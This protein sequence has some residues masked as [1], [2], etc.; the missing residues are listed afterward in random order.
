MSI[1]DE[2]ARANPIPRTPA[3]RD[4]PALAA[5]MGGTSTSAPGGA[6][7]GAN[8]PPRVSQR[9][10][11]PGWM[12]GVIGLALV[13]ACAG[14]VAWAIGAARPDGAGRL[15]LGAPSQAPTTPSRPSTGIT[16]PDTTLD[17]LAIQA[18]PEVRHSITVDL[19]VDYQCRYC[20]RAETTFGP[21]LEQLAK[22][23]D[24]K[25]N[26]H[27]RSFLD[28]NLGNTSSTMAAIAATCADTV[29]AFQ[30]YHD[31]A[32]AHQPIREGTGYTDE[33]LRSTFAQDAG[34]TA[35]KLTSFQQCFDDRATAAFVKAMESGNMSTA[36]PGND[37]FRNGVPAVPTFLVDNKTID[38]TAMPSDAA[39]MLTYL[40]N[41]AGEPDLAVP[42]SAHPPTNTASPSSTG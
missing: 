28:A 7:G 31:V 20:A 22:Q 25:L 17:G 41:L 14:G 16:P 42:S 4:D 33:Q 27:I 12:A 2:L 21:A 9:H 39:G 19:H 32:L 3:S 29:G 1:M 40:K 35:G 15:A 38:L 5:I 24:I 23:G 8:P 36:I 13:V 30:A 11:P 34:I 6:G 10:V 18:N 37:D 26:Y